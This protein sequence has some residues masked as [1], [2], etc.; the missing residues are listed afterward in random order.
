MKRR[1]SERHQEN[2]ERRQGRLREEFQGDGIIHVSFSALFR[3]LHVFVPL[4]KL[5]PSASGSWPGRAHALPLWGWCSFPPLALALLEVLSCG[6]SGLMAL[7]T[8]TWLHPVWIKP[9]TK[10]AHLGLWF[11]FCFWAHFWWRKWLNDSALERGWTVLNS[12]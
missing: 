5:S 7:S 10:K 4:D 2:R 8:S 3:S 11:C 9:W 1:K 6:W 12:C